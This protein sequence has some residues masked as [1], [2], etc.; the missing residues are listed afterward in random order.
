SSWDVDFGSGVSGNQA[1]LV[2]AV[3]SSAGGPIAV[4]ALNAAGIAQPLATVAS[5][6]TFSP[7]V[8]RTQ[9]AT[10]L[11]LVFTDETAVR[12]IALVNV[13]GAS[14]PQ[15]LTLQAALHSR[16]GSIT[17][18]LASAGGSTVAVRP[19]EH[20]KLA[21]SEPALGASQVRD[22]LLGVRGRR[23]TPGDLTSL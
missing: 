17:A 3:G 21:F 15:P 23:A 5:R 12:R 22:Y 20:V 6:W 14:T 16:L 2:E 18:A 7:M 9:G 4:L 13:S 10:R 1:L 19:N 8:V 11:R